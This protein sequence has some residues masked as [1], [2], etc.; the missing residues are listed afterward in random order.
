MKEAQERAR[1]REEEAEARKEAQSRLV[2]K[3]AQERARRREEEEREE[4]RETRKEAQSRVMK[5]AQ[6][7]ARRREEEAEEQAKEAEEQVRKETQPK[8]ER[9]RRGAQLASGGPVMP[10]ELASAAAAGGRR[11]SRSN[12]IQTNMPRPAPSPSLTIHLV[13]NRD[14]S[15]IGGLRLSF[16]RRTFE[17]ELT[18]DLGAAVGAPAERFDVRDVRE[19]SVIVEVQIVPPGEVEEAEIHR[20]LVAQIGDASSKLYTGKVTRDMNRLRTISLNEQHG[21]VSSAPPQQPPIPEVLQP[22]QPP[23]EPQSFLPETLAAP[24][25]GM[26]MEASEADLLLIREMVD[27]L[28]HAV[29]LQTASNQAAPPAVPEAL[30]AA[31]ARRASPPPEVEAPASRMPRVVGGNADFG[32]RRSIIAQMMTANAAVDLGGEPQSPISPR[33]P[34]PHP[35]PHR[36]PH[37]MSPPPPMGIISEDSLPPSPEYDDQS[38]GSETR[39]RKKSLGT[40]P[41]HHAQDIQAQLMMS[42][43]AQKKRKDIRRRSLAR[44]EGF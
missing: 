29:D 15:T 23:P 34:M 6:E 9:A 40:A 12:S 14:Y 8:E 42:M 41:I 1:R 35:M 26:I 18:E 3:E 16:R 43:A 11:R 19:G 2:M 20:R 17:K 39:P 27:T 10:P 25:V 32:A 5:E 21:I 44:V 7:R 31:R 37:R 36:M 4:E 22:S 28:E 24:A 13:L 30:A 33:S 38:P